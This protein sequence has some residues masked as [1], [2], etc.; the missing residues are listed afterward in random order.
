[1]RASTA[2]QGTTQGGGTEQSLPSA[3]LANDGPALE[4]G[5]GPAGSL[6]PQAPLQL[7]APSARQP[8]E[9]QLIQQ[10]PSIQHMCGHAS[11]A[12]GRD[13]VPAAAAAPRE[14]RPTHPAGLGF[15]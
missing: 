15:A 12:A 1:M 13:A 8:A 14:Q 9:L 2:Q 11:R 3:S 7:P 4:A 6:G 5:G 10:D